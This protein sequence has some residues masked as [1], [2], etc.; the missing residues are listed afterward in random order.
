MHGFT[1]YTPRVT[2]VHTRS[3][4]SPHDYITHTR[5]DYTVAFD[6]RDLHV[7][8]ARSRF[9]AGCHARL[10]YGHTLHPVCLRYWTHTAVAH[11]RVTF[12]GLDAVGTF[13]LR[14]RCTHRAHARTRCRSYTFY[15]LLRARYTALIWV[16]THT[17]VWIG[18]LVDT[19][20]LDFPVG[21]F[22]T[23][24]PRLHGCA[25][26][27]AILV[28]FRVILRFTRCC[29]WFVTHLNYGFALLVVVARC[30]LLRYAY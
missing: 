16:P 3:A 4:R 13:G 19:T 11:T 14:T 9:G 28:T 8:Y 7:G 1:P 26:A 21:L 6:L 25:F 24:T 17:T 20:Q 18:C 5:Y 10:R 23:H 30:R 12:Y 29:V 22:I 15:R 2:V 27:V